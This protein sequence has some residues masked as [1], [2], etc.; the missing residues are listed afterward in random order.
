MTAE[1]SDNEAE[2][3]RQDSSESADPSADRSRVATT[4]ERIGGRWLA[5]HVELK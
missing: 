5:S 4:M 1:I 2:V 3:P